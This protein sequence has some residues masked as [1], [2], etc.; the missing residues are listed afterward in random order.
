MTYD[1]M[2]NQK[3]IEVW[4]DVDNC[5]EYQESWLGKK[6]GAKTKKPVYWLGLVE[7]G[8]Q[9]YSYDFFEE[10]VDAKVF[11]DKSL[12]EIWDSISLIS[13]DVV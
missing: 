12:R 8:S 7:D 4:F 5:P 13:I 3:C 6:E 10:F 2:K 11:H 9:A 1:V